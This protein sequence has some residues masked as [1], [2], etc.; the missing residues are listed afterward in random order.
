MEGRQPPTAQQSTKRLVSTEKKLLKVAYQQVLNDYLEK[1]YIRRVPPEEPKPGC[2][3]PLPHFPVVWPQ[4]ATTKVRIVFDGLAHFEG[5][6]LKNWSFNRIK[7]PK[8]SFRPPFQ[9][10][11]GVGG[12]FR[13][14]QPNV[15]STC[16]TTWGSSVT[17]FPVA[18][19]G[20][21]KGTR[22]FWIPLIRI[23]WL[24]MSFLCTVHL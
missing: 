7:P 20:S 19:C 3:W 18:R 5:K 11:K 10:Q 8:R 21:S 13:R 24:L 15:P 16:D 22:S 1:Q 17:S 14:H 2:E 23:R 9:I 12:S 6:S 4:K